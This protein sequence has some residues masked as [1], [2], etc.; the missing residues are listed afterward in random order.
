MT[1]SERLE[2]ALQGTVTGMVMV[3]AVLALLWGIISL[4]KVVFYDIPNKKKAEAEK[5]AE[6]DAVASAP[7]AP[8]TPVAAPAAP[9]AAPAAQD[10]GELAAII[11]AAV[12]AMI[13][14]GDYGNEFVGGFR[15]VSFKRSTSR[16]WNRK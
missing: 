9:V 13:E 6:T 4:S 16:A 2:Y 12:A 15:V 14:S 7:A 5:S 8:V 10:D 3:F 1:F 11:T